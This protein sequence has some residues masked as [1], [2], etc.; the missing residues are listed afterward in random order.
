MPTVLPPTN[1]HYSHPTEASFPPKSTQ[2]PTNN[3]NSGISEN[4]EK[5]EAIGC[6][7][8]VTDGVLE[9]IGCALEVTD[10]VLEATDGI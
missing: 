6:V 9:V 10:G 2:S 7:L 1:V 3:S 8:E 5:Q 4:Q